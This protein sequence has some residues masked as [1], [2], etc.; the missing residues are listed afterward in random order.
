MTHMLFKSAGAERKVQ[1]LSTSSEPSMMRTRYRVDRL[2]ALVDFCISILILYYLMGDFLR[3]P[4]SSFSYL[5]HQLYFLTLKSCTALPS[6][7]KVV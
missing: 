6:E 7:K 3:L 2:S 4:P 5:D 1:P